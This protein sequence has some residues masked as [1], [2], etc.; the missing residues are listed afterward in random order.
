MGQILFATFLLA[1]LLRVAHVYTMNDLLFW[2]QSCPGVLSA[3]LTALTVHLGWG[4]VDFT[5]KAPGGF[6]GWH[7]VRWGA[8][9]RD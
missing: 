6:G 1:S 4:S 8:Y 2:L 3:Y 5:R 9:S 7:F